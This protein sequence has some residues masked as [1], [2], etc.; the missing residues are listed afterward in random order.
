M[1]LLH[2]EILLWGSTGTDTLAHMFWS[3]EIFIAFQS[4]CF[5]LKMICVRDTEKETR[6]IDD[7]ETRSKIGSLP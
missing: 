5:L 6:L 3:M 2:K 4:C 7:V 1:Q